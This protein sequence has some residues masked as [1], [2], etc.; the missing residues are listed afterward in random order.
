M[1]TME[2]AATGLG[3]LASIEAVFIIALVLRC[4]DLS[5]VVD[6][7]RAEKEAEDFV[8][9]VTGSPGDYYP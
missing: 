8:D 4:R 1:T 7:L 6:T 3:I 5:D 2:Y 9:Q